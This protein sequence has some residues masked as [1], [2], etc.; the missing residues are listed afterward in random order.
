MSPRSGP[1]IVAP[2]PLDIGP[3]T[4][5]TD[6]KGRGPG[7][8][9]ATVPTGWDVAGNSHGG[10]LASLAGRALRD[11]TGRPD[12]ITFTAHYL[13]T[14]GS[15]PVEI[16]TEV[17]RSGRRL[18]TA[19]ATVSDGERPLVSVLATYGDLSDTDPAAP[20]LID[21]SPPDLP[22]PSACVRVV[23]GDPFPPAFMG[24]VELRL[25][26]D[27]AGFLRGCRSGEARIRGWL[28]LPDGE[29][30]D[31]IALLT[32]VDAFPPTIFNVDLPV[33]WV[34]TVELTAHLR[35][36]PAPGPLACEVRTRFV[37]SGF[38]EV[39][40]EYWDRTGRLVA[41]SRQLALVPRSE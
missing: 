14:V 18:C 15:G 24:N 11:A 26:P 20:E 6:V 32:A 29:E 12:P 27:D 22:L 7:R 31:S 33:A 37:S 1:R 4:A 40:G 25:H 38:L 2:D 23:P 10:F 30:M 16:A 34:P 39:D 41:Q 5:A 19:R 21:G 36:R 3:F 13:R 17:V 28:G 8:Y 9:S 35:C